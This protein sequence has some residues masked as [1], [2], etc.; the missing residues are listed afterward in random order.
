[1]RTIYIML[2]R[3]QTVTARIIR[4][5]QPADYSHVSMGFEEDVLRMYSSCRR[6]IT[7]LPAGPTTE[8]VC[9]GYYARHPDT[10]CALYALEVTDEAYEL[11]Q[12]EVAAFMAFPD[13]YHYN[14]LGLV[15]C[16]MRIAWQRPNHFFCSQFVGEILSRSGALE[17]PKQ[18]TL[19]CPMDYTR[20]PEL[21][22]LYQGTVGN[23]P[24]AAATW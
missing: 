16:R 2:T 17:L 23:L 20:I 3:S 10:P 24:Q 22:F 11:A 6:G 21:T 18:T 4:A 15:S 1:M 19:M 7:P 14:L 9:G 13:A 5:V 12:R 8:H